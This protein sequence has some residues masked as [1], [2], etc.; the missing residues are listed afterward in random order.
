M[1]ETMFKFQHDSNNVPEAMGFK[2]DIDEKCREIIHFSTFTNYFIKKDFFND[3]E[4]A[5]SLLTSVTGILEKALTVCKTE[6][7]KLYT[8]YIFRGCHTHCAE[9]IN[10]WEVVQ[11]ET[12]KKELNKMKMLMELVELRA[13]T[14]DDDRK[15]V[16][17]PKDMFK[18]IEVA[19]EN[20]YNFDKYYSIINE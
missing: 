6:E 4:E 17:T 10:A 13:L 12:D 18:K 1:I 16:I 14:E 11:N 9:A 20:M 8:L 5:P 15:N 7:E 2:E 19:K 3:N